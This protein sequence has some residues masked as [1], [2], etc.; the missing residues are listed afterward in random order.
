VE[1]GEKVKQVSDSTNTNTTSDILYHGSPKSYDDFVDR[2]AMD[3][4]ESTIIS[5]NE[6][7]PE[8]YGSQE[9]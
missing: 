1:N 2:D 9:L 7:K 6:K 5:Y 4:V 3:Y 8:S